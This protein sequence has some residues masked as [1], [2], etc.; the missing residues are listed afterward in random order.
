MMQQPQPYEIINDGCTVY[1]YLTPRARQE[2]CAD[3]FVDAKG[4][5]Y[6]KAYVSAPPEDNKANKALIRLIA[7][8]FDIAPST[9]TIISGLQSRQKKLMIHGGGDSLQR[10]LEQRFSN[11]SFQG[12][13]F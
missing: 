7:D 9:I 3:I 10:K 11:C 1:V 12:K 6:I 5:A 4:Q 8:E 13:L 2:K